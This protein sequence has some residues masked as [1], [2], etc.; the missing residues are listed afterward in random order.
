MLVE[1]AAII[2]GIP[3]ILIL[4]G[5]ITRRGEATAIGG[6]G[7]LVAGVLLLAS[8]LVV[9]YGVNA[10][11]EI[12]HVWNCSNE[13]YDC[14][15]TPEPKSCWWYNATQCADI[16]G[17]EYIGNNC[18]GTPEWTCE[19]LYIYGGEEKCDETKGCYMWAETWP[20]TCDN[21]YTEYTYG[22]VELEDNDNLILGVLLAFFGLLCI[23][24]GTLTFRSN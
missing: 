23:A 17:C 13:T 2:I 7:L 14:F 18:Y 9:H 5:Y 4:V 6:I 10:T 19:Q 20:H 11:N 22:G 15:G 24:V 16:D 21:Y 3:L 12:S 8:P 1:E